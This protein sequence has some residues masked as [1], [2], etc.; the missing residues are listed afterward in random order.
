MTVAVVVQELE[1]DPASFK[2]YV[3]AWEPKS[4]QVCS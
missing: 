1:S 2:H 4:Q 3:A